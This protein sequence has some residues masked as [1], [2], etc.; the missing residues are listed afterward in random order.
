VKAVNISECE[1]E[2]INTT[3]FDQGSISLHILRSHDEE[4]HGDIY[5]QHCKRYYYHDYQAYEFG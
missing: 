1:V 4:V 3:A 2:S 5:N